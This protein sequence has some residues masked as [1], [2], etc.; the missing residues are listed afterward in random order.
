LKIKHGAF[1]K[2]QIFSFKGKKFGEFEINY[3][4]KYNDF[5]RRIAAVRGR[6]TLG[7]I[8]GWQCSMCHFF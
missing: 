4:G 8:L 5:R 1:E 3:K 6:Q 2:I 7:N